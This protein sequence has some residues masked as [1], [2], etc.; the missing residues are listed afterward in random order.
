MENMDIW[1]VGMTVLGIVV[2]YGW[3]WFVDYAKQSPAEWDD[4]LVEA[5]EKMADKIVAAKME[6]PPTPQPPTQ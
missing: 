3:K 4:K 2:G 1:A 5:A 6:Q